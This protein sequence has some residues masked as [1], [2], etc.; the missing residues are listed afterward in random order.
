MK[1]DSTL[2]CICGSKKIKKHCCQLYIQGEAYP[3]TPEKLM[4]SR[5]TAFTLGSNGQYLL[6]TWLPSMT[7]G[8]S[9]EELSL[10]STTWVGLELLHKSQSG[11]DAC[12]EFNASFI[13]ADEKEKLHHE[14][15]VFKRIA[16]KWLYV[17]GEV[18]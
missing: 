11:D 12:V 10:S 13:D 6:D 14:N 3:K 16:G 5:Y 1:N 15:S 17:G 7:Q 9:V 4:R 18:S 2:L 8:L